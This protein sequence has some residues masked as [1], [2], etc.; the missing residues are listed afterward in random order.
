MDYLN[1]QRIE[2]ACYENLHKPMIL[3]QILHIE[4]DLMIWAILY[5]H[6]KNTKELHQEN[7][8]KAD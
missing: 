8:R 2:R 4:M 6:L 1:R 3:L 5:V 7:I